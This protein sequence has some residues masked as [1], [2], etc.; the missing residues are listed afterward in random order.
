MYGINEMVPPIYSGFPLSEHA[1]DLPSNAEAAEHCHRVGGTLS[2][3]HPMFDVIEL[4]RVFA[5]EHTYSVEAKELPV[6][7]A[8]GR[9]DALDVMSYPGHE[10]ETCRLWY[11]LL[12]CGLR[13]AATSGT[14]TFMNTVDQGQFSNPPA[15]DR[16]YAL[17]EGKFTTE[18]WCEAVRA[19][20]TFVT[21]GP[22]LSLEVNTATP[23]DEIAVH[24]GDPI[25][26][27]VEAGSYVPMERVE[28]IVNGEVVATAP[29]D[30]G[31]QSTLLSH[32]LKAERSCWIAARAI[33][34][35]HRLALDAHVF[36]H[37]SPVYVTV[38]EQPVRDATSAEY[39]VDWIDRLIDLA[40]RRAKYPDDASRERV[41]A[42]FREGQAYYRAQL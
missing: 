26:V 21:N 15:G 9:I 30:D 3:A 12:N 27:V 14:D 32:E 2:Y 38:D 36:A 23:G 24:A 6:D 40:A 5:D 37:T 31:G 16:V 20:R 29:A 10:L 25:G 4:D 11:R 22:M 8:L 33:G 17:V 7:A 13:L 34:P 35:H 19:G 41:A 18:S 28:L 42:L 1:H 39:F